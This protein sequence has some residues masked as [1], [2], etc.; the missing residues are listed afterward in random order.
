MCSDSCP[1]CENGGTCDAQ[2][3]CQ[4]QHNFDG[5]TCSVCAEG[6][7]DLACQPFPYIISTLPSD[8]IDTGGVAVRVTGYNFGISNSSATFKCQF[9][10]SVV[11]ATLIANDELICES[12]MMQLSG[13]GSLRSCLRVLVDN[14]ASY[15]TVPFSFYGM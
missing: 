5:D 13:K 15:N 6:F 11:N 9:G 4:C 12:P 14:E 1:A 8:A 3:Q 10:N 2:A 7:F